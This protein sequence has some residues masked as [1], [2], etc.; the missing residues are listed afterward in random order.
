MSQRR[1]QMLAEKE[2]LPEVR[3]MHLD[4]CIVFLANQQNRVAFHPRPPMRRKVA[5]ELVHT[6]VCYVDAKSHAGAQYWV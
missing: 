1:M 4:K 2:L 5:L 6:N 3:N